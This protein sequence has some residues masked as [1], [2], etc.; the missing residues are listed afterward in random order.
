M[1]SRARQIAGMEID[2]DLVLREDFVAQLFKLIR[3]TE[4]R[5]GPSSLLPPS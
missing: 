1:L 2:L 3:P 4:R 5:D